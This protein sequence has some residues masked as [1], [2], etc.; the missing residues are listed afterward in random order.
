[1]SLLQLK[2]RLSTCILHTQKGHKSSRNNYFTILTF[3][4]EE[5]V[6]RKSTSRQPRQHRFPTVRSAAI[7]LQK[8]PVNDFRAPVMPLD[9]SKES[10][11]LR[12]PFC[13]STEA[14]HI[15]EPL[16]FQMHLQNSYKKVVLVSSCL[17]IRT[18]SLLQ[19]RLS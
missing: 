17:S 5:L 13:R 19:N 9:L 18:N 14:E 4:D 12:P 8:R 10:I 15:F 16:H 2:E 1:M 7:R 11:R 3:F 6:E